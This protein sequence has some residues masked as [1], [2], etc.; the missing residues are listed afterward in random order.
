MARKSKAV[1]GLKAL[2]MKYARDCRMLA[3]ST[4]IMVHTYSQMGYLG[5]RDYV[6]A[7]EK[8]IR[9]NLS[10]V[11]YINRARLIKEFEDAKSRQ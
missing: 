6:K 7:A 5:Y 9:S 11:Y 3:G 1:P 2:Q 8:A 10:F 4:A